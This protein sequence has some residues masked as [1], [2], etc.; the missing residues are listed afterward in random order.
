MTQSFFTEDV[1]GEKFHELG[2]YFLI[3]IS[4]T[5]LEKTADTF[6]RYEEADGRVNRFAWLDIKTLK[7]EYL[8]PVFVREGVASLPETLTL[9]TEVQ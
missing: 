7:D 1:T 9:L 2:V 5:E 6:E 3:D 4:G 8:Y